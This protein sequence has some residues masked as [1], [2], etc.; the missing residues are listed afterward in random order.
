MKMFYKVAT[1]ILF[2]AALPYLYLKLGKEER[3]RR[4]GKFAGNLKKS[5][6]IHASS[7]G[8]VNAVK[9][10][11][12]KLLLHYP[13]KDIIL[14]TMTKTGQEAAKAIDKNLLVS[15]VPLDFSWCV[16]RFLKMID[17][18][19]LILVE[20]EFWPNMLSATGNRKIPIVMVN[21]R[22]SK[23]SF[24]QYNR[25]R[26][27]WKPFWKNIIEVGAQSEHD[28]ERFKKL[29]FSTVKNF[30]NLKFCLN[31]PE[32]NEDAVRENLGFD[33]KDFVL[34]WGSSRPGEEELLAN[35]YP[36]LKREIK[37]LKLIIVPRHLT[38]ME[39]V[40]NIFKPFGFCKFSDMSKNSDILLVDKMGELN[41]MYSIADLVIVGGSFF[42]F[43]GHNPLEPAFFG[44]PIIMGEYH[45]NCRGSVQKL[46]E[47]EAI[48]ISQSRELQYNILKL[49]SNKDLRI[50][51]G[52]NA[53]GTLKKNSKSLQKSLKMIHKYLK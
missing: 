8:E 32:F 43:G 38:R 41:E 51:L 31:L 1:T 28:A 24:P 49:Y 6:W 37:D 13:Q 23:R 53:K 52:R 50:E 29:G 12:K 30:E 10:L 3:E 2:P 39:E 33:K 17:P 25:S 44:K 5:I 21:G 46:Q 35:I 47:N 4:L 14:T 20:T 18:E 7:M 15:Y 11:V 45:Q 36:E 48:Q 9:E 27:F 40:E 16:N 34:V 26:F 42:D 19:L 22:I